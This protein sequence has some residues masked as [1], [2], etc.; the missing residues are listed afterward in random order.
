M[1]YIEYRENISGDIKSRPRYDTDHF[2]LQD[3][4][5]PQVSEKCIAPNDI[6]IIQIMDDTLSIE[7]PL[8]SILTCLT[9]DYF[10]DFYL[11]RK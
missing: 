3:L 5:F 9:I 4:Q 6:A 11:I 7:L 2:L 8:I 10:F 1:K